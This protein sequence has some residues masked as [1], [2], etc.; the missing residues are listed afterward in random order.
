MN[1]IR[2]T[3]SDLELVLNKPQ[4]EILKAAELAS[5]GRDIA[6]STISSV[7]SRVRAEISA[8]QINALDA[9][10]LKIPPE[11][12]DCA[13]CLALE[14]LQARI[15]DM[16]MPQAISRRADL[17]RETLQRVADG[18]L[19][20]TPPICGIKTAKAKGARVVKSRRQNFS[21]KTMEGL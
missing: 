6:E 9:D 8:G 7:V 2:I 18:R 4:L 14:A 17:A 19:P 10:H 5:P 1:W 13:L 20:V 11:L 16:P 21:S 12:K 15:P 3:H